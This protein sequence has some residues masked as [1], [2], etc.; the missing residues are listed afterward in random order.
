MLD[1]C[2]LPSMENYSLYGGRG[3]SVCEKWRGKSG[4]ERFYKDM[5]PRPQGTTL[6]RKNNDGNYEPGNCRW[7]TPKEQSNNRREP[8]ELVT[9][10]RASLDRGRAKMWADPK[11]R[12]ALLKDRAAR[13]RDPKTG[14]IMPRK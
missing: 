7:A 2:Y 1:R 10:K 12:K 8:P 14:R 6:D 11:L 13:P 4:F 3:V 5:G 9:L